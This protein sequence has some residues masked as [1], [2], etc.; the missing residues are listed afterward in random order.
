MKSPKIES[1]KEQ[2]KK[3][4]APK[5]ANFIFNQTGRLESKRSFA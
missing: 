1:L 4:L 2:N 3:S 5:S